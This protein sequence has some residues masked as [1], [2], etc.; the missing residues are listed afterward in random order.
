[1]NL[2]M[3]IEDLTAGFEDSTSVTETQPGQRSVSKERRA[4]RPDPTRLA[5]AYPMGISVQPRL[6]LMRVGA[7]LLRLL[8][9]FCSDSLLP[10]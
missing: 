5:K 10:R 8:A 7:D 3:G 4:V 9:E 1:M 2:L 6:G